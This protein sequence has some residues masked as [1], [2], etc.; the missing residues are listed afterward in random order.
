MKKVAVQIV[1]FN[2]EPDILDCLKLLKMQSYP[3]CRI[4]VIDN[5][6]L[7]H[8]V[9]CTK[10]SQFYKDITLVENKVNN[11]FAGGHNQAFK[12]SESDYVLVLNPDVQL[13]PDYVYHLVQKLEQDEKIGATTGK[14]FRDR[15]NQILDS[16]GLIIKK[17]R[18]TFDRGAGEMDDGQYDLETDIFGVSGAAAMFR[19]EMITDVSMHGEFFDETFFA[20]KEDVD[21]AWRAQLFGWKSAFVPE[22][23]AYHKRGWQG[24]KKRTQIS[25]NIRKH[26]YINRYYTILKNDAL[27]YFLLHL[28]I[29]LFYEVL[30]LVYAIL[31]E[32]EI[33]SEWKALK[34]NFY[35]MMKKRE[36]VKNKRKVPYSNIYS[37]F[38]GIW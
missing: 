11:G 21:V 4:L 15:G 26:S 23:I 34:G 16:T 17:N 10:N 5:Q 24:E 25:L 30:S 6:S 12:L 19:R 8:T 1:T 14:L 22:A 7:D 32:R 38:K 28:P 31:K 9:H 3:I 36:F 27:S 29:I 37:F 33:L 2:S 18:R 20:Y 13:H 35:D